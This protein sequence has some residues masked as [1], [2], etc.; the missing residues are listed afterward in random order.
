MKDPRGDEMENDLFPVDDDGV[1]GV[2]P[3]LIAGYDLEGRSQEV[4][5]LAFAFISPLGA[6]Y[7][8]IGHKN[9]SNE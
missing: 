8:Q 5:D 1:A 7:E 3:S 9:P 6:E 2:V 4:Y